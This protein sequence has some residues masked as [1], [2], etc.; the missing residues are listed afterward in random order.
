[1]IILKE[2]ILKVSSKANSGAVSEPTFVF[3]ETLEATL[4]N[5]IIQDTETRGKTR[6]RP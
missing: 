1:M 4:C 6:Q 5:Q 2:I 3:F